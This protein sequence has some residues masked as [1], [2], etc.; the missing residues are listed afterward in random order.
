MPRDIWRKNH[1]SELRLA[2]SNFDENGD[3]NLARRA[4]THFPE[5]RAGTHFPER[6]AGT[7]FPERW[8]AEATRSG[9]GNRRGADL[10]LT[11]H[12]PDLMLHVERELQSLLRKRTHRILEKTPTVILVRVE[13]PLDLIEVR[14]VL[15]P[16][17]CTPFGTACAPPTPAIICFRQGTMRTENVWR[18]P[19]QDNP[20]NADSITE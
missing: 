8:R 19:R 12:L 16:K 15:L 13:H 6:R 1:P 14:H 5:R 9:A 17:A 3:R 2:E 18:Q 4:R 11:Y 20:L 7:Y 10:R